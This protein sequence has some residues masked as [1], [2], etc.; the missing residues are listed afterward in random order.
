VD[1]KWWR[2]IDFVGHMHHLYDDTKALLKFLRSKKDSLTAWEK[3]GKDGWENNGEFLQQNRAG[4]VTGSEQKLMNYYTRELESST[5]PNDP[6]D[7]LFNTL[8]VR[9]SAGLRFCKIR[10]KSRAKFCKIWLGRRDFCQ[11]I[12]Y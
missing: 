1:A 8:N 9:G 11:Y 3:V 2:K 10:A 12:L 5:S 7:R 6:L 4:H